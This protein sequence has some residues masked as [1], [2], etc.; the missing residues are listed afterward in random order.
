MS[1]LVT[2]L[3]VR[4]ARALLKI[5]QSSLAAMA[6]VSV[7][8]VKRFE[9]DDDNARAQES[10]VR[11]IQKAIEQAGVSFIADG[12]PSPIGG[13]GVRFTEPAPEKWN[14]QVGTILDT[15]IESLEMAIG[16]RGL[17]NDEMTTAISE[18][19]DEAFDIL[20]RVVKDQKTPDLFAVKR[21]PRRI[22][23]EQ[24]KQLRGDE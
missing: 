20:E 13:V 17:L 6:G 18:A 3:Q 11:A 16:S 4:T 10:S 24:V 21:G 15:L 2:P 19:R 1:L 5:D 14:D 7:E 8:T 9:R 12:E 22:T 23:P